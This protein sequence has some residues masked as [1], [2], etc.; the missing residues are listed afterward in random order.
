MNDDIISRKMAINAI[1]KDVMGGLNYRSILR[2]LPSICQGQQNDNSP[3][4]KPETYMCDCEDAISRKAV[5]DLPKDKEWRLDGTLERQL[6]NVADVEKLPSV[7]PVAV[8]AKFRFDEE[9]MKEICNQTVEKIVEECG[10]AIS[11]QDAINALW[12][13]LYDYEDKTEKQFQ[14]SEELDVGDWIAHRIFVQ[15]MS[16]IDRQAILDLPSVRPKRKTGEWLPD[17]NNNYDERYICSECKGNY[18]VDTCMGK[19]SWKYCPDCGSYNGGG[20][21]DGTM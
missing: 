21:H 14:E 13:A 12:K 6:I 17:N 19:P 9:Q 20:E 16:D 10:D 3:S 2:D 1:S 4:G 5:L 7:K 11:R 8:I 18:K 15:N